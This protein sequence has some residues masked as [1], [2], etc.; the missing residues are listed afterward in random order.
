MF[1]EDARWASVC[2]CRG[3]AVGS[4]VN[5]GDKVE[6]GEVD[7]GIWEPGEEAWVKNFDLDHKIYAR[8]K[9]VRPGSRITS[10]Q[11]T[12]HEA[13]LFSLR[14]HTEHPG[15]STGN[16][17]DPE[18]AFTSGQT[19]RLGSKHKT[20]LKPIDPSALLGSWAQIARMHV[21]DAYA[22]EYSK[23]EYPSSPSSPTGLKPALS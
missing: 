9:R 13:N 5:V 7:H 1:V 19:G 16:H 20:H 18:P 4:T 3:R 22:R 14:L 8:V 12:C 11:K 21:L 23:I 2:T 10:V 17:V 6:S 15:Q